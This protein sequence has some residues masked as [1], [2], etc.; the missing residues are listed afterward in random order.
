MAWDSTKT[1]GDSITSSD[2]NAQVTDQKNRGLPTTETYRGSDCDGSS[3][4]TN[5]VLTLANTTSS[6]SGGFQVI[7]GNANV[8]PDDY[9]AVHNTSASTVEF[10]NPIYDDDYI[11]VNY[12]T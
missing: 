12:F 11:V 3:G 6:K 4:A 5:R 10:H 7:V 1:S 8:H 9:T 2:W